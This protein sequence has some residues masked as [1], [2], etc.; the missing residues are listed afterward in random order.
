[1]IR[2]CLDIWIG[3]I[4]GVIVTICVHN[5]YEHKRVVDMTNQIKNHEAFE[6]PL[7][8]VTSDEFDL[9]LDGVTIDGGCLSPEMK[10]LVNKDPNEGKK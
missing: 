8:I 5:I 9:Y 3:L 7:V 4:A 10:A 6:N 1:M 2:Y